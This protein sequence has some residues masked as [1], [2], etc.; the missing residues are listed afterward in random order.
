M[1]PGTPIDIWA[2]D[3]WCDCPGEYNEELRSR[4]RSSPPIAR[5][6]ENLFPTPDPVLPPPDL[7]LPPPDRVLPP[8]NYN[9]GTGVG[10]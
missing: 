7:V 8:G 1:I 4:F 6:L 3:S 5:T 10:R 9:P 2:E